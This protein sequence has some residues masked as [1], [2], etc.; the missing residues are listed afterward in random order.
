M[1]RAYSRGGS[2]IV[3]VAWIILSVA[4]KASL[5]PQWVLLCPAVVEV[6]QIWSVL[7]FNLPRRIAKS[8]GTLKYSGC[9][10]ASFYL[11]IAWTGSLGC[12]QIGCAR[13][14][15]R[16]RV[17]VYSVHLIR[18]SVVESLSRYIAPQP[19]APIL[20]MA[21]LSLIMNTICV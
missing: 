7:T 18:A 16:F 21:C 3:Q 15:S 11:V 9:S 13:V 4:A 2:Y 1:G 19:S 5:P 10:F 6:W 14:V 12:N 8:L 20:D 17:A